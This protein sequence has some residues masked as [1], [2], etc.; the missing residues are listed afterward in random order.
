MSRAVGAV[1]YLVW[2]VWQVISLS[3]HLGRDV[4]TPGLDITPRIVR[5]PLRCATDLEVTLMAS[6]ITIT[7]G[8]LVLGVAPTEG[9]APRALFVQAL[10]G[11]DADEVMAGL[12]DMESRLLR[13]TRGTKAEAEVS[14]S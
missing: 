2:L 12:T 13:M 7:P 10:Y 11:A 9:D 1:I 8:T 14:S 4:L 5:L 3:V 6:S